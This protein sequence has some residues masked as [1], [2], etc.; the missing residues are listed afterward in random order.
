MADCESGR[1]FNAGVCA[2]SKKG[3]PLRPGRMDLYLFELYDESGKDGAPH[4]KHFGLFD[5]HGH[6]K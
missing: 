3:T 6:P 4:E 2:A 1:R 5:V